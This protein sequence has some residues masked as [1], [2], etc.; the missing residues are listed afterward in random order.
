MKTKR[1]SPAILIA[2]GFFLSVLIFFL[3]IKFSP[4]KAL[5]NFENRRISTRLYDCNGELIQV[6]ALEEG[7]RREYTPLNEIPVSV[8]EAFIEAEDKRFYSHHGIDVQAIFRAMSS[9]VSERRTVSGASTITMQLARIITPRSKRSLYAK[10]KES[11][12]AVRLEQKLLDITQ[13]VLQVQQ[14]IFL[15]KHWMS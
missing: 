4:Y 13:R 14:G 1:L 11:W 6:L 3:V 15:E 7:V 2:G 10:V 8:V 9:N 12:N 5:K